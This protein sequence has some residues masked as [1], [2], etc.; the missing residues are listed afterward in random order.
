MG[1]HIF[2]ENHH[3]VE[4]EFLFAVDLDESE[5]GVVDHLVEGVF[6]VESGFVG[7]LLR[8]AHFPFRP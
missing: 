1:I 5:V 2:L 6:R 8:I 7:R 4:V 3:I